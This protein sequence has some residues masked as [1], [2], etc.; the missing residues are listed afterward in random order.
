M[1]ARQAAVSQVAT[2]D[3]GRR[4]RKKAQTRRTIYDAATALFVARGYEAVT[5]DDVCRAADVAKGTFFLHFPT[6]DALLAEYGHIATAE[7]QEHLAAQ[8][9]TAVATL[10][11]ALRFLAARAE[12]HPALVRLT[13]RETMGRPLAMAESSQQVR[14]LGEIL[15]GLVRRGQAA[16]EL[17]RSVVPEVAGA[18]L[19]GS[20]FAIVNAWAIGA[21]RFDLSEAVDHALNIVLQGLRKD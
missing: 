16:G 1:G 4:A 11:A 15:I 12:R 14:S 21:E 13:V 9:G 7:L 3:P 17:R 6:K 18:V 5:V 2:P 10:R 19:V 20:Y 8:R